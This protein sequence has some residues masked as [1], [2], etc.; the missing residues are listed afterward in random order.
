MYQP[1]YR[2]KANRVP[3]LSKQEISSIG[4]KYVQDFQPEVLTNPQPVDIEAFLEL[5]L[6]MK[7]DYQ[8]LSNNGIYLGMTVFNDTDKVIIYSAETARAEYLHADAKTVIID[9]R[10]LA[11]HQK[12]RLRFTIGHEGGHGVFHEKYYTFNPPQRI[13]GSY[14]YAPVVQCR[15]DT[16]NK[17]PDFKNWGDR[18]WMEWQAN[19]FASA[20][21]MPISAV[22][23]VAERSL[24]DYHH[25]AL[26]R[27]ELVK[28]VVTTFDVS[29][30]AAVYRLKDLGYIPRDDRTDYLSGSPYQQFAVEVT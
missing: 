24:G 23:L 5:Y 27:V 14:P 22:R 28:N 2:T 9:R 10:L 6:G 16:V 18:D 17:R 25:S 1:E 29:R 20:I 3:I 13:Q 12:H 30:E 7:V 8:F 26:A 4:E 21:L 19:R 11:D 15:R